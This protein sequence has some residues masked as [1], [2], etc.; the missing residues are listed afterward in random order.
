MRAFGVG[1]VASEDWSWTLGPLVISLVVVWL[2]VYAY[3][4]VPSY[5][6]MQARFDSIP[7]PPFIG[8]APPPP[9][10]DTVEAARSAM[11][12][13]PAGRAG[14]PHFCSQCGGRLVEGQRF[15]PN[16]GAAIGG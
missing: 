16:C 10:A 9:S 2:H 13:E 5:Q 3:V 11:A 7:P 4:R 1:D 8:A 15:C 12:T 6:A 14:S